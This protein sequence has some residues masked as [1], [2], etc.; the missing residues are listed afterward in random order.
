MSARK[1]SETSEEQHEMAV[2]PPVSRV[3]YAPTIVVQEKV[4]A[5][6]AHELGNFFHKLYYWSDFLK[7]RQGRNPQD[8]T[9]AEMLERTIKNLEDFLKLALDYVHPTQ[10]SFMRMGVSELLEGLLFQV[11]AHL[12][13]TPFSVGDGEDWRG[14]EVQVMVD[15][16][17]LSHAFEV[18]VRH[19][20]MQVGPDSKVRIAIERTV[21][22]NTAGLEVEFRLHQPNEASPLFRTAEAGVEWAVAQKVIA[23]HGGEL[24]EHAPDGREKQLIVFLPLCPS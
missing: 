6:I 8:S 11:R 15:P 17:H 2:R 5:E 7:E 3:E 9:A 12:N 14:A 22:Q 24:S 21:R 13:G 18:A 4:L 10:L 23:L 1:L 19:L 20:T 16:S